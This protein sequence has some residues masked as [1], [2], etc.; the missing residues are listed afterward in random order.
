MQFAHWCCSCPQMLHTLNATPNRAEEVRTVNCSIVSHIIILN[1]L[2]LSAYLASWCNPH[3]MLQLPLTFP[4]TTATP[5][6]LWPIAGASERSCRVQN[7][8]NKYFP[9]DW[10]RFKT[11]KMKYPGIARWGR[12]KIRRLTCKDSAWRERIDSWYVK[13]CLEAGPEWLFSGLGTRFYVY[14]P[15]PPQ[16]RQR[17][18]FLAPCWHYSDQHHYSTKWT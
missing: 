6:S 17:W 10:T 5:P 14:A 2:V 8:N 4:T 12:F 18:Q 7:T 3:Q 15:P 9:C 11:Q 1:K 13:L 16:A